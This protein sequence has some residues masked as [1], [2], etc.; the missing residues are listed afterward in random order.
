MKII[1]KLIG[2]F[3]LLM[4]F[5][6]VSIVI[7]DDLDVNPFN[8]LFT[9]TVEPVATDAYQ[10]EDKISKNVHPLQKYY[11]KKY[12]LMGTLVSFEKRIAMVRGVGGRE[13][14]IRIDD[15]LGNNGGKVTG[16]NGRGIEVTEGDKIIF[17]AVRNRSV[18]NEEN[19]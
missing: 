5:S 16:I 15:L 17:L 18:S 11:I 19:K 2:M 6:T 14:F 3:S 1:M 10:P 7:A 12:T 8:P 4:T 9:E 13:F